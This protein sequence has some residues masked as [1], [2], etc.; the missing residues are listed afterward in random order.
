[1][2]FLLNLVVLINHYRDTFYDLFCI[3][4]IWLVIILQLLVSVVQFKIF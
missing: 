4:L 1:M 3:H 2:I